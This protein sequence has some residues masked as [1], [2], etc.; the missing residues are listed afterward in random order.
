MSVHKSV[1]QVGRH[2]PASGHLFITGG[3]C[4][5]ASVHH[6]PVHQPRN[7][8]SGHASGHMKASDFRALTALSTI[9][10]SKFNKREIERKRAGLENTREGCGLVDRP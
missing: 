7:T 10:L 6:L 9:F 3:N 1:H 4:L 2:T 8:A 5:N